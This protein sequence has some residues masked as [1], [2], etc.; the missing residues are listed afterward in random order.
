MT[1][2]IKTQDIEIEYTDEYSGLE[3]DTV[4]KIKEIIESI[5]AKPQSKCKYCGGE[6]KGQ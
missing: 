5:S 6:D 2:R 3:N 1:I 4:K